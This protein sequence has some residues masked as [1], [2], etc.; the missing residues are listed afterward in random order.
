MSAKFICVCVCAYVC[1]C[2]CMHL[3]CVGTHYSYVCL[4]AKC[5]LVLA[6]MSQHKYAFCMKTHE[7]IKIELRTLS[8]KH[9]LDRI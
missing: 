9:V 4:H 3:A 5:I 6:I 1:M 7:K 8:T 2:G